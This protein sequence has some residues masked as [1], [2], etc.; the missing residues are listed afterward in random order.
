MLIQCPDCKKFLNIPPELAGKRIKCACQH[1]FAVPQ[2]IEILETKPETVS[3]SASEVETEETSKL[4]F[5]TP[6]RFA[7]EAANDVLEVTREPSVTSKPENTPESDGETITNPNLQKLKIQEKPPAV[8]PSTGVQPPPDVNLLDYLKKDAQAEKFAE[9]FELSDSQLDNYLDALTHET[10]TLDEARVT[11]V[12]AKQNNNARAISDSVTAPPLSALQPLELVELPTE[13]ASKSRLEND[14]LG[15]VVMESNPLA[16]PNE[17]LATA[18]PMDDVEPPAEPSHPKKSKQ[19]FKTHLTIQCDSSGNG[20]SEYVS[21][22][23]LIALPLVVIPLTAAVLYLYYASRNNQAGVSEKAAHKWVNEFLKSEIPKIDDKK[24]QAM[25]V[26]VPPPEQQ[27]PPTQPITFSAPSTKISSPSSSPWELFFH[28][29]T[30]AAKQRVSDTLKKKK[31]DARS[32]LAFYELSILEKKKDFDKR[33]YAALKK[34]TPSFEQKRTLAAGMIYG[35]DSK[36][37]AFGL[38]QAESLYKARPNEPLLTYYLAE[39]YRLRGDVTLAITHYRK[40]LL[41]RED[42]R[43]PY[44]ELITLLGA[45]PEYRET[46]L[47][48]VKKSL[49]WFGNDAA[50]LKV[51]GQA[52]R[53]AGEIDTAIQVY[54]H[55]RGVQP[56]SSDSY[57]EL[58]KIYYSVLKQPKDAEAVYFEGL[59]AVTNPS[60]KAKLYYQMGQYYASLRNFSQAV[61]SVGKA[62]AIEK[63]AK[64]YNA[65]GVIYYNAGQYQGALQSFDRALALTKEPSEILINKGLAYLKLNQKPEA[66]AMFEKSVAV[67]ATYLAHYQ[68]AKLYQNEGKM[69]LAKEHVR[70]A[71]TLNPQHPDALELEKQLN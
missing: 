4:A 38:K 48:Y 1:I 26:V 36:Q 40:A 71:I 52:L 21:K 23:F 22:R 46:T 6:P 61:E 42:F 33:S 37:R 68:L 12:E 28:G 63:S 53:Q 7:F 25:T 64:G 67:K 15:N 27:R 70:K 51:A 32:L 59:K 19:K 11:S 9:S 5:E 18:A 34:M 69:A 31:G 3:D 57:E 29:N 24:S 65:L 60:Q 54:A 2:E 16:D 13:T 62:L 8:S 55:L 49:V 20:A 50:V 17:V 14:P 66:K 47:T 10:E 45:K 43:D 56:A 58:G 44:V 41:L 39:A 30:A 35:G